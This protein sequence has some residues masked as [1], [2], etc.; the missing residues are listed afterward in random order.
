[1]IILSDGRVAISGGPDRFEILIYSYAFDSGT[2]EKQ[3]RNDSLVVT[4]SLDC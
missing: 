3:G 4:D 1:M 2:N